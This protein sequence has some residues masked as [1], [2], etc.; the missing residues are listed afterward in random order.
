MR[1]NEYRTHNCG[2][3][4]KENV[5]EDIRL[6]GWVQRIRNLGKM[7]FIDLRDE[8]GITQL[9]ISDDLKD[10]MTDVREE[11]SISVSGK[12]V[13]RVNKNPEIPTGDIEIN[14]E[15]IRILGKCKAVLPFEINHKEGQEVR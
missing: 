9:V 15:E 10:Q 1:A 3:L 8:F 5:G 14:V 2:E 12:V 6:A 13:E 7:T 4:R 11:C